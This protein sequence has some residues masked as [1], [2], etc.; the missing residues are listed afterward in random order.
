MNSVAKSFV[1]FANLFASKYSDLYSSV[2][3]NKRDL[4]CVIDDVEGNIL[5]DAT[6]EDCAVS[7]G[8][9]MDATLIVHF[10]FTYLL[11]LKS[12]KNDGNHILSSDHFTN[13]GAELS[14][15]IAILY[16]YCVLCYYFAWYS[17][18]RSC[19]KYNIADS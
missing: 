8:D 9:V 15:H 3:Y 13:A 19:H 5:S 6:Y 14:V 16:C 18:H 17:T 7:G 11:C 2:S 12:G 10:T 1:S 4:Q